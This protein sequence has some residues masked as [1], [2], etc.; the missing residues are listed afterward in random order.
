MEN[1]G[2]RMVPLGKSMLAIMDTFHDY[3]N[4]L[5]N[6]CDNI[7]DREER[8][9]KMQQGYNDAIKSFTD[10]LNN[11]NV[12]EDEENEI[13]ELNSNIF[14]VNKTNNGNLQQNANVV[15]ENKE[16]NDDEKKIKNMSLDELTNYIN[17]NA[18]K[19]GDKK[20]KK[21][22]RK[23]KKK[24][25]E[26]KNENNIEIQE[27]KKEEEKKKENDDD[28]K[29]IDEMFNY[30]NKGNEKE[31]KKR[32][33]KN[34]KGK[35]NEIKTEIHEEEKDEIVEEYKE[36]LKE[37]AINNNEITKIKPCLSKGF[38]NGLE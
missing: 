32:K 37:Y 21:R 26:Q 1:D 12:E 28:K 8:L 6:Q 16:Q 30:I 25:N 13:D 38:I 9:K 15:D 4:F 18:T 10:K 7:E 23:K 27:D 31:K 33:H 17:E 3:N 11:I 24:N 19:E 2:E 34:K 20:K 35:K 22:K 29:T 14:G 5:T 36:S